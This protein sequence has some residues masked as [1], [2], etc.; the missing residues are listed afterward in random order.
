[1]AYAL[2][3]QSAARADAPAIAVT[4]GVFGSACSLIST[5][6]ITSGIRQLDHRQPGS[7]SDG[8]VA[9]SDAG[10]RFADLHAKAAA[11]GF[12]VAS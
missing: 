2:D 11:L 12:P 7:P 5:G 3:L 4:Q 9:T 1:M 8:S 10:C 6:S